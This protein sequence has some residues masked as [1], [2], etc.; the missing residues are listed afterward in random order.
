MKTLTSNTTYITKA[1]DNVVISYVYSNI[2][3][4]IWGGGR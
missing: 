2:V 3:M 1:T 4:Q